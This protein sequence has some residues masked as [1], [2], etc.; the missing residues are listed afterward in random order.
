MPNVEDTNRFLGHDLVPER[1]P[2]SQVTTGGGWFK[3]HWMA[4]LFLLWVLV[5]IAANYHWPVDSLTFAKWYIIEL[6]SMVG[7]FGALG[8]WRR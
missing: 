7:L 8:M 2:E 1:D 6:W 3:D 4:M 5:N